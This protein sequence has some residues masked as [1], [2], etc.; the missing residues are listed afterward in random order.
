[1]DIPLSEMDQNVEQAKGKQ[2]DWSRIGVIVCFTLS[3]ILLLLTL[4][5]PRNA[6]AT[7]GVRQ[8]IA[9]VSSHEFLH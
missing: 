8:A 7:E 3:A 9:K 6:S 2:Q 4:I 5:A 1:M